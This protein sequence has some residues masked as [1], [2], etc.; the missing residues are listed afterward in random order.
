MKRSTKVGGGDSKPRIKNVEN[1]KL[2]KLYL[3]LLF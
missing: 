3:N 2:L 1:D